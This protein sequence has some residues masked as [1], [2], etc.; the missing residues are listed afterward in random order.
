MFKARILLVRHHHTGERECGVPLPQVSNPQQLSATPHPKSGHLRSFGIDVMKRRAPTTIEELERAVA[1]AEGEPSIDDALHHIPE[2][3]AEILVKVSAPDVSIFFKTRSRE[4]STVNTVWHGLA[5]AHFASPFP[6]GGGPYSFIRNL[7]R[8][9]VAMR[10]PPGYWE[11]G[12]AACSFYLRA[13]LRVVSI[14]MYLHLENDVDMASATILGPLLRRLRRGVS[15]PGSTTSTWFDFH[16]FHNVQVARWSRLAQPERPV[17]PE[18]AP[19]EERRRARGIPWFETRQ[20]WSTT[21][22]TFL[23]GDEDESV[24]GRLIEATRAARG[25]NLFGL[26]L[27]FD[28]VKLTADD[29]P[30]LLYSSATREP[31]TS[32][33]LPRQTA[34]E[35]E[36]AAIRGD[37]RRCL[38]GTTDPE[39]GLTTFSGAAGVPI[40][41]MRIKTRKQVRL[42][43]DGLHVARDPRS[44]VTLRS[45]TTTFLANLVSI[46]VDRYFEW[47]ALDYTLGSVTGVGWTPSE[48]ILTALVIDQP[49]RLYHHRFA[50]SVAPLYT[51]DDEIFRLPGATKGKDR[52][53]IPNDLGGGG[54]TARTLT[55]WNMAPMFGQLE[56]WEDGVGSLVQFL[57]LPYDLAALL[58]P[59]G[60]T[61]VK[62]VMRYR[63]LDE[64]DTDPLKFYTSEEKTRQMVAK[65]HHHRELLDWEDDDGPPRKRFIFFR[66]A[67]CEEVLTGVA[68][69]T[70]VLDFCPPHPGVVEVC[71]ACAALL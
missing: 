51:V 50:P 19:D 31:P 18:E 5:R 28:R 41:T 27:A 54:V 61:P 36:L 16:P 68:P 7:E 11:R 62:K 35:L 2:M 60:L 25:S 20:V 48:L 47:L 13:L 15:V 58:R 55:I 57:S 6:G 1:L 32:P 56:N 4:A 70:H 66:A 65:Q 12:Y 21:E 30:V 42:S 34:G 14:Q 26:Q 3:L 63:D 10:G 49:R 40:L 23:T 69:A 43:S 45:F 29:G 17:S 33:P 46:D 71:E 37:A 24:H 9:F 59:H 22:S 44:R 64:N 39:T 52:L 53:Q 8:L 67:A 38:R